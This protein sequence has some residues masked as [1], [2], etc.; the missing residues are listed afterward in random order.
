MANETVGV[1]VNI[2]TNAQGSIAEL[3]ALKKQ[4]KETAAGSDDFKRLANE[5]DDLEDKIKGAKQGA[6]DW[7]DQLAA[8]PGPLGA[9][10]G[11]IN[12][13]KVSTVSFGTALKATGIGLFV[14]AIGG[15]IAAF[16]ESER[17]SKKLQPILIGFQKIFNGIFAAIEPVF[18]SLLAFAESALPAVTKGFGVAYSAISAFL[19]GIGLLGTAVSKLIGGDFSGAW[20]SAKEAV[21]GFGDRYN[22][23]NK[24]FIAGTQEVTSIEKE[25]LEK[26]KAAQEK[27]AE[28]YRARQ[29]EIQEA[30]R[31]SLEKTRQIANEIF[32]SEIDDEKTRQEIKLAQ[33]F[34]ADKLAIEQSKA[35]QEAKNAEL[36][37]LET[38][39][40]LD[41]NAIKAQ[42]AAEEV[43]ILTN[44]LFAET[45]AEF[46]AS[47][48]K[49]LIAA[50]ELD[51][52]TNQLLR[53]I[54]AED[55]AS[56]AKIE[57]AEKEAEIKKQKLSEV[58]NAL[59]A[60]T[61]IVGKD[62]IA[63]KA[64]AISTAIINTFQG[65][66]EALKQKS[67]LPSPFDVIAKVAN[68]GAVIAT[69][70]KTVKSI[71]SVKV[72]AVGGAGGGGATPT[73]P[74]IS[75]A[76]PI[77][78][79]APVVNTRTQL[80]SQS[81]QQLGNA[82]NRAYVVESDIT[83]QQERIRRINRAARLA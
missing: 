1:N 25:E 22:E 8:A 27:A 63:G 74:S 40:E 14:A 64:L 80:D 65:A 28:E 38:K 13:L 15:L 50:Q 61:T 47:E 79:S 51:D 58:G 2:K 68:V 48:A 36:L 19:Q 73:I 66:T 10:G 75:T 18:D 35:T 57:I 77:T 49:K 76:A 54:E 78:P 30:T 32:L 46:E 41:R 71:V 29:K 81:I 20:D 42:R 9:V 62:T 53:E 17:A 82:T 16:S 31:A 72:P 37:A 70:L 33:Q 7:V 26:R 23:A 43:D 55:K 67:V 59:N 3:K 56:K 34:E 6:G 45:Q 39:Y 5:I 60:L 83:N 11:A 52:I 12:K 69:G 21:T 4:L 44:K 24:R